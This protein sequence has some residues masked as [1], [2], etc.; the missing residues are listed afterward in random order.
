[1]D[2]WI[3]GYKKICEKNRWMVEWI[4]K[5]LRKKQKDGWMDITN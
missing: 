3:D 4:R 5:Q 1:M 2:G